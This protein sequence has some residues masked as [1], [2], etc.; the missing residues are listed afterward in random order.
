LYYYSNLIRVYPFDRYAYITENNIQKIEQK[1]M[2]DGPVEGALSYIRSGTG[3]G[4]GRG[5]GTSGTF[6][7]TICSHVLIY[8]SG[9]LHWP[10]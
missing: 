6:I 1:T 10:E 7:F 4:A 8:V 3:T 5:T 2:A 9:H